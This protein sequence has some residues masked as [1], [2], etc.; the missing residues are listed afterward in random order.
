MVLSAQ[1]YST[2]AERPRGAGGEE[3]GGRGR[4][5]ATWAG[6]RARG[7]W[8]PPEG[9]TAGGQAAIPCDLAR[10]WLV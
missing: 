10:G 1:L 5:G 6:L 9:G 7:A 3:A 8:L 2:F 4:G